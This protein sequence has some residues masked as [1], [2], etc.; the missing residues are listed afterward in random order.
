MIVRWEFDDI[1]ASALKEE[2][3]I[4]YVCQALTPTIVDY[5]TVDERSR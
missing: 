4:E 1:A 5:T 3:W 2:R